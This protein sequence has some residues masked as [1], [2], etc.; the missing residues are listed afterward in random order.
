MTS[1]QLRHRDT[2]TSAGRHRIVTYNILAPFDDLEEYYGHC[3]PSNLDPQTRLTR[4]QHQLSKEMEGDAVICLQEVGEEF[5]PKLEAFFTEHSYKF[6]AGIW[7]K[8]AGVAVA[9]PVKYDIVAKNIIRVADTAVWP[10]RPAPCSEAPK[11]P[12]A[13]SLQDRL[14]AKISLKTREADWVCPNPTCKENCFGSRVRCRLCDTPN[15]ILTPEEVSRLPLVEDNYDEAK[16]KKN[17]MIWVHLLCTFTGDEF[18]VSTYHMPCAFKKGPIMTM[19][20]AACA[21]LALRLSAGV[22]VGGIDD[23]KADIPE[24]NPETPADFPFVVLPCILAGDFNVRPGSPQYDLITSGNMP[25]KPITVNNFTEPEWHH[26][27]GEFGEKWSDHSP[28]STLY[29]PD[30]VFDMQLPSPMFSAYRQFAGIDPEFTNYV[31]NTGTRARSLKR[32][33]A[34]SEVE[35]ET[36]VET[37]DYI[38]CNSKVRVHDVMQLPRKDQMTDRGGVPL[39]SSTE[40]SDHLMIAATVQVAASF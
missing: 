8:Y 26:W 38:F 27:T 29:D 21:R 9:V 35:E 12:P 23:S 3:C 19:H 25:N 22:K 5:A 36:F 11:P 16:A 37:L 30:Y 6:I 18:C 4:I 39:P 40:P 10:V 1:K 28:K 20:A 34:C 31:V 7:K 32:G 13:P 24:T 15:P 17:L 33:A 14:K 2:F